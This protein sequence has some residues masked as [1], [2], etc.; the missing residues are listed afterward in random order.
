[1]YDVKCF[2]RWFCLGLAWVTILFAGALPS[3]ADFGSCQNCQEIAG[4]G[5]V[6]NDPN[7][8]NCLTSKPNSRICTPAASYQ[9]STCTG[10]TAALCTFTC[11]ATG[12]A[13]ERGNCSYTPINTTRR[14]TCNYSAGCP[15]GTGGALLGVPTEIFQYCAGGSDGFSATIIGSCGDGGCVLQPQCK[16]GQPCPKCTPG[17]TGGACDFCATGSTRQCNGNVQVCGSNGQFPTCTKTCEPGQT[18]VCPNGS[19]I[20]CDENGTYPACP[21]TQCRPGEVK[22]CAGG[23]GNNASVTCNAQGQ[24]PSCPNDCKANESCNDICRGSPECHASSDGEWVCSWAGVQVRVP[25]PCPNIVRDPY[26][27]GLV[28]VPNTLRIIGVCNGPATTGGANID[29][30]E[31]KGRTITAIR[32]SAAWLCSANFSDATW[33]MDERSWNLGKRS[34]D[35]VSPYVGHDG[36]RVGDIMGGDLNIQAERHGAAI[37]HIYETSSYDKPQNGNANHWPAYQVQLQTNWTLAA[38]FQFQERITIESCADAVGKACD[39]RHAECARNRT[40]RY[41][42]IW[43]PGQSVQVQTQIRG[44]RVTQDPTRANMCGVIGVPVQQAQVVLTK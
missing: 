35:L 2:I 43:H 13:Y 24:F 20:I 36:R 28:G 12:T 17:Q 16:P 31:C 11:N 32:G 7:W 1:M 34:N 39:C 19:A 38:N 8:P 10:N 23:T 42:E 41:E 9:A 4:C 29:P 40:V 27:R 22:L 25:T 6:C 26:P 18:K 21:S 14:T 15:A 5:V 30:L 33:T 3:Q 37:Q 44:A